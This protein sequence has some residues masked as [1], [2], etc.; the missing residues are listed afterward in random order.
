MLNCCIE[1]KKTREALK[2]PSNKPAAVV[3]LRS[4]SDLERKDS[5]A[6]L[7]YSSDEEFF[8]CDDGSEGNAEEIEKMDIT[9]PHSPSHEGLAEGENIEDKSDQ[10]ETFEK[11]DTD[12]DEG[13]DP[14]SD[15]NNRSRLSRTGSRYADSYTHQADGRMR[16]FDDMKLLNSEEPL[17][18]PITQEPAPMTEDMLE[19]HAEVLAR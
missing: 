17:Y 19:E 13:T 2:D 16:P 14:E 11:N 15:K 1:H 7:C 8:E 6:E 5:A 10:N 4:Q 3:R 18:V 12:K 9:D